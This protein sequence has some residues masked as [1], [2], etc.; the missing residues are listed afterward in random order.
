MSEGRKNFVVDYKP[1]AESVDLVPRIQVGVEMAKAAGCEYAFI[2]EDDDWYPED[3]LRSKTFGWDFF[4]Y[5]T[6]T[7]YHIGNSTY[8]TMRHK[9][10]SSLFCTGFRIAALDNFRWP[11]R[12]SVFLDLEL[13]DYAVCK[14]KRIVLQDENPCLGIKHGIGKTGGKAHG[15]KMKNWDRDKSYLKGYVDQEAFEF[16]NRLKV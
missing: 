6:T 5:R 1:K 7:Y 14:R 8:Q 11:A 10:R 3:Y 15:W 12:T 4:G 9:D 2:V 13:W 16:Y